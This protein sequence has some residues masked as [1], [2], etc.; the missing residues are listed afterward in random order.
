MCGLF[1]LLMISPEFQCL[2][3]QDPASEW[4]AKETCETLQTSP[5]PPPPAFF[6][7]TTCIYYLSLCRSEVWAQH[8]WV[9]CFRVLPAYSGDL[10]CVLIRD[11][12]H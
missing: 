4:L 10:G 5:Q 11:S 12:M 1:F 9:L 3:P 7:L 8:D 6:I 2:H